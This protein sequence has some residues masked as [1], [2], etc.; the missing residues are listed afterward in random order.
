MSSSQTLI[1]SAHENDKTVFDSFR[2]HASGTRVE[3]KSTALNIIR[4][5]YPDYHVTEVDARNCALFEFAAAGKA[6]LTHL[7]DEES[8]DTTRHWGPVGNG[9]EKKLH[10]GK[11][12]D[13]WR[14]A[15]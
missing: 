14:F 5:A 13:E 11:L 3:T 1:A 12:S 15:R 7:S 10:P 4:K 2:Q 6:T 9:I 8:F